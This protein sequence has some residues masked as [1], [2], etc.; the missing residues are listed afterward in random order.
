MYTHVAVC[1]FIECADDEKGE[2]CVKSIYEI[3]ISEDPCKFRPVC[4]KIYGGMFSRVKY[5]NSYM[6]VKSYP[7]RCPLMGIPITTD[8]K[9]EGIYENDGLSR[10]R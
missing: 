4:T 9:P 6:I 1:W 7:R 8:G 10:R 2:E 5:E 3:C